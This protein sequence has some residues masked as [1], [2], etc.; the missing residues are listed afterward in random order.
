MIQVLLPPELRARAFGVL[1]AVIGTAG[2][3][4]QVSGG[5]LVSADLFGMSWHPVFW[6]NVPVGL[7]TPAPAVF[8]V[9]ESRTAEERRLDLAGDGVC[10]GPGRSSSPSATRPPWPSWSGP[11]TRCRPGTSPYRC[12]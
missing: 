11:G 7:V 10:S 1:G 4:G 5:L 12:C 3:A 8:L 2:V 6:V 9:P